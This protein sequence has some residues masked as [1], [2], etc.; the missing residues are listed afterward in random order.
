MVKLK[1]G[2]SKRKRKIGSTV[3]T[4]KHLGT[5]QK[6]LNK[7]TKKLMQPKVLTALKK[8]SPKT[9]KQLFTTVKK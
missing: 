3:I 5:I 2:K 8:L 9:R 4:N 6:A 1:G 7:K